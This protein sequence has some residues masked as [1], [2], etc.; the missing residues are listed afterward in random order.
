MQTS[1]IFN[2]PMP[3]YKGVIIINLLAFNL[4]NPMSGEENAISLITLNS[5][6][7]YMSDNFLYLTSN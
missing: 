1:Q 6:I 7:I 3:E 5:W 2:Y 4:R